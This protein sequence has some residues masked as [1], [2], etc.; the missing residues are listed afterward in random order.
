MGIY[1]TVCDAEI[2]QKRNYKLFNR[3]ITSCLGLQIVVAAALTALGAANGSRSAVTVFGAINT[4][5]AGFLTYLKGT[6]LPNRLKYYQHEWAKIREYIEQKERDFAFGQPGVS[7]TDEIQTIRRMYDDVR[8]DVELNTP[9]RFVSVRG[10]GRDGP[11]MIS[12]PGA[13]SRPPAA[14]STDSYLKYGR[15]WL[16]EKETEVNT[17]VNKA[18]NQAQGMFSNIGRL[19]EVLDDKIKDIAHMEKG[20]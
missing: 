3:L 7:V 16:N 1:T 17:A 5:I 8:A 4:V 13:L 12:Q 11:L 15:N 10:L 14:L 6:G 9:D 18:Q 20:D 2:K 19:E